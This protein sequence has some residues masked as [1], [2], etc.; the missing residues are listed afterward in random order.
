MASNTSEKILEVAGKLFVKQGYTATSIRQI[1]E[2]TGIGKATIYH[3]FKDKE[4]IVTALMNQQTLNMQAM[5]TS[6][7]SVDDPY[8]RFQLAVDVSVENLFK[9]SEIFHIVRREIPSG[10]EITQSKLKAFFDEY[11]KFLSESI[12]LGI[13]RGLF[14]PIVPKDG[15]RILLAIIQGTFASAYITGSTLQITDEI[16]RSMLDIFYNGIEK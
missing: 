11:L 7:K 5:L 15:A 13:D 14:R 9:T 12:Q 2:E 10:I 4:A 3:H 6:L 16:K 8:K 1:A